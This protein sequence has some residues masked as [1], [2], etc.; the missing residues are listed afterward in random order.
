MGGRGV[1]RA[2]GDA[3]Q[4]RLACVGAA[5]HREYRRGHARPARANT[6]GRHAAAGVRQALKRQAQCVCQ[7]AVIPP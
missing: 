3:A 5:G 1:D 4:L 7:E 2:C 6:A